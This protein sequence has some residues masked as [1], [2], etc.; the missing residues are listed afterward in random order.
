MQ[1]VCYTNFRS[2]LKS[3]MRQVNDDADQILVTSTNPDDN[4][5][6][7]SERDWNSMMETLRVYRNPYLFDKISRGLRDVRMGKTSHHKLIED[8]ETVTA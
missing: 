2:N 6:V 3:Y 1:A 7:V 4:V 8:S 5:V